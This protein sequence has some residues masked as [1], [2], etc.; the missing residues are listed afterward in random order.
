MRATTPELAAFLASRPAE[1]WAVDLFSITLPDGLTTL[2]WSGGDVAVFFQGKTWTTIG[3]AFARTKWSGKDSTDVPTMDITMSS[4]GEDWFSGINVKHAIHNGLL[5]G[6]A[7]QLDRAIGAV[8]GVVLGTVT[9]FTGPVGPVEL[10]A[11][12]TKITVKGWM[13]VLQQYMPRNTYQTSCIHRLY[14]AGCTLDKATFTA[15]NTVQGATRTTVEQPAPWVLPDTS[16]VPYADLLLGAL[17]VES[18][19]ASGTKR[20]VAAVFDDGPSG[21]STTF[22]WPLY[23]APNPGD[24]LSCALGCDKTSATCTARFANLQHIRSFPFI[25]PAEQG[26]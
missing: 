13:V 10:G 1:I 26:L 18:G 9:L 3:P 5:T 21:G 8:P 25:P 23:V 2:R 24:N 4:N 16:T 6:A 20:T 14:D 7:C 22:A 12:T 11:V 15:T 17:K 19:P